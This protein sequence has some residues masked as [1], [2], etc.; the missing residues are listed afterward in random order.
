MKISWK[1]LIIATVI[2][3]GF[4]ALAAY[5]LGGY[6]ERARVYRRHKKEARDAPLPDN[7]LNTTNRHLNKDGDMDQ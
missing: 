2:P 4:I 5:E 7:G 3:G 1:K 6:L